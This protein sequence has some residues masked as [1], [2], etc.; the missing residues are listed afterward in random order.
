M[1]EIIDVL[2]EL[3]D[4]EWYGRYP[5]RD[6]SGDQLNFPPTV[7]WRYKQRDA[8][9]NNKIKKIVENFEGNVTWDLYEAGRNRNMV[10]VPKRL[11]EITK[12]KG[13]LGDVDAAYFLMNEEPE[14]GQI[15][16]K[17]LKDLAKLIYDQLVVVVACHL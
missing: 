4:Y 8:D 1:C 14:F 11:G 13:L 7:I 15:A 16:N 5:S 12:L 2:G 17:D 10:L 9:L 3:G 6:S